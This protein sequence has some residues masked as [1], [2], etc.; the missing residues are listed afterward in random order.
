MKHIKEIT[1]DNKIV[2]TKG[3]RLKVSDNGEWSDNP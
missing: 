3:I 1:T 2:G